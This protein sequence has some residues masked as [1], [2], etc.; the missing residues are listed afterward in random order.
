MTKKDAKHTTLCPGCG[1][2]VKEAKEMFQEFQTE[3]AAELYCP[4]CQQQKHFGVIHSE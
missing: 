3:A 4:N 2:P 1:D